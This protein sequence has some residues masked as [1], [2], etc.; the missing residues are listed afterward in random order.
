MKGSVIFEYT[1][2]WVVL[3]FCVAWGAP[4][5]NWLS[6]PWNR[7]WNIWTVWDS[8]SATP[9]TTVSSPPQPI[10]LT[11]LNSE[12]PGCLFYRSY[13]LKHWYLNSSCWCISFFPDAHITGPAAC[14][15]QLRWG[16]QNEVCFCLTAQLSA[17]IYYCIVFSSSYLT[18]YPSL[19]SSVRF[20]DLFSLAEEYED[21]SKQPKSRRKAP[22]SSPRSRKGAAPQPCNE[23]ESASSSASVNLHSQIDI[24]TKTFRLAPILLLCS[25]RHLF[26]MTS[27]DSPPGGRGL[28]T[29]SSQ[30]ETERL[31]C[32]RFWQRLRGQILMPTTP[33]ITT[34][35][36]WLCLH[37][38]QPVNHRLQPI[39]DSLSKHSP[40]VGAEL[41]LWTQMQ[42]SLGDK[43]LLSLTNA[44][45][46][47]FKPESLV[48]CKD[49]RSGGG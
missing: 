39:G 13:W 21:S 7:C 6:W 2:I 38:R 44:L 31:I 19:L 26:S 46:G 49:G 18:K 11:P 47:Y 35:P 14:S 17:F 16:P 43:P 45:L 29:Q 25:T 10:L 28:Q 1:H 41:F 4:A 36:V 40:T 42:R 23:E 3:C 8:I 48:K 34:P 15:G 24:I 5:V 37:W 33:S 32:S 9:R 27:V 22:A 20:S 30:E 12:Q